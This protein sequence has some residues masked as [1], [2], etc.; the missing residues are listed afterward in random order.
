MTFE[1]F[2]SNLG[3]LPP[4][5]HLPT[6]LEERL[7]TLGCD[8][9]SLPPNAKIWRANQTEELLLPIQVGLFFNLYSSVL[10]LI[11]KHEMNTSVIYIDG[12][13]YTLL[14]FYHDPGSRF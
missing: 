7:D 9:S 2:T 8:I 6:L 10:N 3:S 1:Q 4:P 12:F 14:I 11:T 13:G 5:G